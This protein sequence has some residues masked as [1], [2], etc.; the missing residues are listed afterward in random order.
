MWVFDKG[1]RKR[2]ALNP[3]DDVSLK[4]CSSQSQNLALTFS[5][6]PI[7]SIQARVGRAGEQSQSGVR[8]CLGFTWWSLMGA[9][10][11]ISEDYVTT[12]APHRASKLIATG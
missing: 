9:V 10:P 6:V 4:N 7:C 3:C 5:F 8:E 2:N 11:R 12:F 1:G